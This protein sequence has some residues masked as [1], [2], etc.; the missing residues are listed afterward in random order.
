MDKWRNIQLSKE[1]EEGITTKIE[2]VC[3]VEVFQRTFAGKLWTNDNFNSRAFTNTM[4]GAWRSKNPI[5]VQ[6]VSKNLFLFRFATKRNLEG[7]LNNGPWS[8][9]RNL[10]VISRVS[11]EEQPFELKMHFGTFWVRVYELPLMLRS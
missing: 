8:F 11:G 5:E 1:E 10:I 2:E 9:D 6:E 3:K 4:I 7:V